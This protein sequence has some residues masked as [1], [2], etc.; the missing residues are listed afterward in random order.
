[1]PLADAP[2]GHTFYASSYFTART[3]YCDD[4]PGWRTLSQAYL[5]SYPSL[6]AAEAAL[7]S[8]HLH[9]PC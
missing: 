6:A 5:V 7:P 3:I 9:Q 4:D 1:L 2:A 8:Y